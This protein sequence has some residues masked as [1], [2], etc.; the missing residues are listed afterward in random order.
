ML[1]KYI[2]LIDFIFTL[3]Y[4]YQAV[5]NRVLEGVYNEIHQFFA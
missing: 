1:L 4:F 3:S 2:V 5:T